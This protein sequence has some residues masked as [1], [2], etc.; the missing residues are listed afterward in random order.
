MSRVN[1]FVLIHTA[2][3][4]S[5]D[6]SPTCSP[7]SKFVSTCMN[8]NFTF[9][10]GSSDSNEFCSKDCQTCYLI[11]ISNPAHTPK[12]FKAEQKSGKQL[13]YEFQKE[14]DRQN[15]ESKTARCSMEDDKMVE[16]HELPSSPVKF[17]TK[18]TMV[19][20]IAKRGWFGTAVM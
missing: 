18:Q 4:D 16:I 15:D 17:P 20:P 8:C 7:R 13:V 11:Y 9:R 14:L 12:K 19:T 10:L 6:M 2:S 3:N 5:S 1:P